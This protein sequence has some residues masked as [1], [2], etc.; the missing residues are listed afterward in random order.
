MLHQKIG[1]SNYPFPTLSFGG[2][3]PEGDYYQNKPVASL[4]IRGISYEFWGD[5]PEDLK[6]VEEA[7]RKTQNE[8]RGES[9]RQ[10][11]PHIA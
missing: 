7:F 4:V 6:D 10:M 11:Q 8:W 5:S 3:A 2:N 1:G 9:M